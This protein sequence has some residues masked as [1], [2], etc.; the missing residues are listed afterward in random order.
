MT[1]GLVRE[2]RQDGGQ[3]YLVLV[4]LLL[5]LNK[6]L[7]TLLPDLRL[8]VTAA[9]VAFLSL[10]LIILTFTFF[11]RLIRLANHFGLA[12]G[13]NNRHSGFRVPDVPYLGGEVVIRLTTRIVECEFQR[14]GK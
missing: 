9:T 12:V 6:K 13:P 5:V 1:H 8:E 10:G 14:Y 2:L 11:L 7:E 4:L 3:A